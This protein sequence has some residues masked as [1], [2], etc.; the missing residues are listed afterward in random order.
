MYTCLFRL[1][2]KKRFGIFAGVL[3]LG[4][5]GTSCAS[6]SNSAK[7]TLGDE[8]YWSKI[9]GEKEQFFYV[10]KDGETFDF[11]PA[12][13]VNKNWIVSE[14]EI[15]KFSINMSNPEF[16]REIHLV[17]RT[18][19][20]DLIVIP[21]KF[22]PKTSQVPAQLNGV[23]NGA[24]YFG[25]R[26]DYYQIDG[27]ETNPLGKI[28]LNKDHFG[29]SVGGFLG[30]GNSIVD[31]TTTKGR[32]SLEYEGLVLSMGL[33]AIF[34]LNKFTMGLSMGWDNLIDSNRSSW[35]Y[36]NKPWLGLAI[37]INLN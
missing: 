36:Q 13:K 33:A 3:A 30:F 21:L 14:A 24:A 19:D 1:S 11:F 28:K 5:L 37:G 10:E 23:L 7:Y 27:K 16:S 31:P 17:K 20:L 26:L 32:V 34:A 6:I 4:F 35:I 9:E 2:P 25:Y 22:R 29:V 12:E 18:F 15:P 8:V